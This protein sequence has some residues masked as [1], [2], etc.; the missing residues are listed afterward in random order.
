M[1]TEDQPADGFAARMAFAL[2]EDPADA[3]RHTHVTLK[4]AT[5][6]LAWLVAVPLLV[7]YGLT[8]PRRGHDVFSIAAVL[9]VV[10]PFT[11]AVIANRNH[12]FTLGGVYTV[13]TLLMLLPAVAIARAG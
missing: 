3:V 4:V 10:M 2:Q 13:L 5:V 8:G 1:T 12:R 9:T 11:A 6:T 7:V